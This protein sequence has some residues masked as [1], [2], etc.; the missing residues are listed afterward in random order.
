MKTTSKIF[1]GQKLWP[2]C[3]MKLQSLTTIFGTNSSF[4]GKG[5]TTRKT[6]FSNILRS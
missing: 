1:R 6:Q 3:R 2:E 4:Q 5:H